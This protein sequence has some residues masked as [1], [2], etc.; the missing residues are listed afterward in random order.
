MSNEHTSQ[1][2]FIFL[3]ALLTAMVAMSIDTMLPAIGTIASDFSVSDPGQRHYIILVLC[4]HDHRHAVL[5][6]HS[7]STGRKPAI[8]KVVLSCGFSLC[9]F[10]TN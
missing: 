3:V 8:F 2:E 9:L 6:P 10:S 4:R 7:D 1:K 5:W